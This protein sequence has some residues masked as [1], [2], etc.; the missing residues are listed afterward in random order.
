ME[1]KN[2]AL[3]EQVKD[4]NTFWKTSKIIILSDFGIHLFNNNGTKIEKENQW[5]DLKSYKIEE[6]KIIICFSNQK[7]PYFLE[8][9]NKNSKIIKIIEILIQQLLLPSELALIN[10][11]LKS[12]PTPKSAFYRILSKHRN[13]LKIIAPIIRFSKDSLEINEK[14][15]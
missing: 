7:E 15:Y 2:P 14:K 8:I 10:P 4:L 13:C 6:S 9:E 1:G 11:K 5:F 3:I 12:S